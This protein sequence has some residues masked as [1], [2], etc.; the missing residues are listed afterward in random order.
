M[1]LSS[2]P[3]AFLALLALA[4]PA[5]CRAADADKTTTSAACT[6]TNVKSGA[7]FD[8][9]PDT[10]V[11]QPA[12]G[13]KPPPGAPTA[14]YVANGYD[15]GYNFTL[16]ICGPVLGELGNVKGVSQEQWGNISAYYTS[17]GDTYSLGFASRELKP[18]GRKLVLQY[19]GGSLCGKSVKRS[20]PAGP[21]QRRSVHSGAAYT[22]YEDEP[23]HEHEHAHS[24]SS[25]SS[26]TPTERSTKETDAPTQRKSTTI[27]F[28]CDR[29]PSASASVS[30]VGTD[31]DEC[32][33]FF[34]VRSSHA[35]AGAEPHTPG[36]V[37]PGTVFGI[38]L[39]VAML[40]YLLGGIF[41]QRTVA[42]QRGW[43]QLPNYSLW[44]GI[45]SF[46]SDLFVASTASCA[47]FL[48]NRR[49]YHYLA[50]SPSRTRQNR[51]R[52]A[53]NRLIDQ[54]DEEWDD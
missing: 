43:R 39:L 33:Y 6:A 25:S 48:P 14:N 19:A 53:E 36:S 30:F 20:L 45:W 32:A 24:P 44:A 27:S 4:L 13:T 26:G 42:N 17:K 12:D 22:D 37:G 34:E 1:R 49:G 28:L 35:C 18:R 54:Y 15:Y 2:S 31:P 40:V 46:V 38:I 10:A 3:P 41:Y 11:R 7:F 47:R 5:V 16:N 29:D 51:D 21:A 23:E 9:R 50:G 8:L 52:E